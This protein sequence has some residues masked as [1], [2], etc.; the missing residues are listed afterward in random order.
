MSKPTQYEEISTKIAKEN[1]N[2]FATFLVK[3][4]NTCIIKGDFRD[5]LK[6]V[7]ITVP[8]KVYRSY[9]L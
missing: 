5:Q 1:L 3:N 4:I 9:T 8:R 7:D 6:T 2:V